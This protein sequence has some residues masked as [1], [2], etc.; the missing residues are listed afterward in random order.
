MLPSSNQKNPMNYCLVTDFTPYPEA[1]LALVAPGQGGQRPGFLTPWLEL[2]RATELLTWWSAVANVDLIRL[3][4]TAESEEITDTANAQPLLVSAGLLGALSLFPHPSDAFGKVGVVAGHSVGE[5]T[6]AAGARAITAESAMVLVR[7]RGIA[8]AHASARATTGMSAI[9][10]GERE[11]VLAEIAKHQLVAANENGAGQI[12]VAGLLS[13]LQALELTPPDG[14]RVRALAV[15]GAFHTSFMESAREH[16]ATLA[17]SVTVRDPRTR[18]L[19]NSDGS[20]IHSGRELLNRMVGQISAPVRW[21]L[22]MKTMGELGVT[23]VIE[24]PPAGTLVGLLKRALPEVETLALKTPEDIPAAMDIIARHGFPSEISDQP[25]WR[26][27]V[28]PFSGHFTHHGVEVGD[29]V[30]A[31]TIVG[32]IA[33]RRESAELVTEHGGTLIEFMVEDG[34]P[35]CP[36]QPIAR[37]HPLGVGA[38]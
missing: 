2:P 10:G 11:K 24:V 34:D 22:C 31:G 35:V 23:A 29:E 25:T 30:T 17:Q 7:E 5:F 33:N 21:D 18:V 9:L 14:A 36:G 6:A 27:I 4:T 12:V 1:M 3:G 32:T 16:L 38:H 15:G 19:T 13:D 37:L 26:M 8:M 28:A 20:V